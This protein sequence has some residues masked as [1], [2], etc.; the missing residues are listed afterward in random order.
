[1][2]K[3]TVDFNENPP[4]RSSNLKYMILRDKSNDNCFWTTG[5]EYRMD[6]YELVYQSDSLDDVKDYYMKIRYKLL[7][8]KVK[9]VS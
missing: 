5:G 2:K 6:F 4:M 3:R 1:M 7:P 8:V 9:T